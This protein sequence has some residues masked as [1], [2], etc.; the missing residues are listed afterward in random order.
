MTQQTIPRMETAIRTP[1]DLSGVILCRG[2]QSRT[3]A[4]LRHRIFG[5]PRTFSQDAFQDA[6]VW[7]CGPLATSR[8]SSRGTKVFRSSLDPQAAPREPV[9]SGCARRSAA[10]ARTRVNLI[11]VAE[12]EPVLRCL[13]GITRGT[14]RPLM[15]PTQIRLPLVAAGIASLLVASSASG[16]AAA[17]QDRHAR[18][19]HGAAATH[20]GNFGGY[21]PLYGYYTRHGQYV[22]GAGDR[23]IYPATC[24]CRDTGYSTR[25]AICRRAPVRTST[26]TCINRSPTSVS[27]SVPLIRG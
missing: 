9:P 12:P 1:R 26:V 17:S 6:A 5:R 22:P 8:D 23:L 13:A 14:R 16:P 24:S 3:A 25:P 18:R 19:A 2:A 27:A 4:S 7:P 21:R 15:R 20:H 10:R 11:F